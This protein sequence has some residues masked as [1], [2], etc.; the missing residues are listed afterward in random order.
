MLLLHPEPVSIAIDCPLIAGFAARRIT[1]YYMIPPYFPF[2]K[3][4]GFKRWG[5]AVEIDSVDVW[6]SLPASKIAIVGCA[7]A[8][9]SEG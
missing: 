8:I 7:E 2:E 6:N 1:K 3:V 9:S 5:C 4:K